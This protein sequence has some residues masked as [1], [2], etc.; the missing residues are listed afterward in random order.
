MAIEEETIFQKPFYDTL[1]ILKNKITKKIKL[2][3]HI[4]I[5]IVTKILNIVFIN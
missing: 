5:S 3:Y 4:L 2:Q 1:L